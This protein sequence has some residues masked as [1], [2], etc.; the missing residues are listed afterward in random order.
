MLERST[1]RGCCRFATVNRRGEGGTLLSRPLSPFLGACC[2]HLCVPRPGDSEPGSHDRRE[3]PQP[4]VRQPFDSLDFHRG[5]RHA[6]I[7]AT[8]ERRRLPMLATLAVGGRVLSLRGGRQRSEEFT[9]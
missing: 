2:T 8:V 7:S 1:Q 5:D 3:W 9:R 4:A 6:E